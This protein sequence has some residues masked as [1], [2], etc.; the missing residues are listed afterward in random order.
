MAPPLDPFPDW[1]ADVI[2]FR[3]GLLQRQRNLRAGRLA[4]VSPRIRDVQAQVGAS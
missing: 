1:S 3:V 2:G 4:G